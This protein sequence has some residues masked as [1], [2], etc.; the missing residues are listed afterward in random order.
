MSGGA[1]VSLVYGALRKGGVAGL[2]QS[3]AAQVNEIDHTKS[4]NRNTAFV[5]TI[6]STDYNYP[7]IVRYAKQLRE[8]ELPVRTLDYVGGHGWPPQEVASA[9]IFYC[10]MIAQSLAESPNKRLMKELAKDEGAFLMSRL[11]N[12]IFAEPARRWA[13]ESNELLGD[14][15]KKLVANIE[16]NEEEQK[17]WD[18]WLAVPLLANDNPS[19]YTKVGDA[20]VALRDGHPNSAGAE[21]AKWMMHTFIQRLT[22]YAKHSK[23]HR[24][25][26]LKLV[27]RF[28]KES[29]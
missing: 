17:A 4:P 13:A 19:Q 16:E 1:R 11:K 28:K 26:F 27:D 10:E 14:Q 23:A 9:A 29:Q 3:A 25:D 20:C 6:G 22:Q 7:E 21:R 8:A 12:P 5:Q 24:K 2:I 18:E 15:L